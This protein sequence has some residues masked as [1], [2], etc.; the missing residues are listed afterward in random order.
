MAAPVFKEIADNIYSRDIDLHLAE[1]KP[2]FSEVGCVPGNPCRQPRR[3][4]DVVQ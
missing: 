2:K 3:V 4:D 1:E